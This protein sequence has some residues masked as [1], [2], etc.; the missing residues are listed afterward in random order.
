MNWL[1][2]RYIPLLAFLLLSLTG[3][4]HAQ[5]QPSLVDKLNL[6][7]AQKEQIKQLRTQFKTENERLAGALRIAQREVKQ[8]KAANPVNESAL[9][10]AYKKQAD[11][12]IEIQIATTRF[13]ERLDAVLTPEQKATLQ[14]L[15]QQ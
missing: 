3:V 10:A 1:N 14:R 2:A 8:M 6:T 13:Y 5:E 15:K 7:A 4:A 11:A 9:R 12:E